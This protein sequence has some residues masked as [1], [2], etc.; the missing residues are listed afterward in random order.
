[1]EIWKQ[2]PIYQNYVGSNLG[3]VKSLNYKHT[4]KDKMLKKLK[5]IKHNKNRN[6]IIQRIGLC[7][8]NK[9]KHYLVHR[10]IYECFYGTIPEGFQIDHID[11]NPQNNRLDN[12]QLLTKS[13]NINKKF[14]DNPNLAKQMGKKIICLNNGVVY[15]SQQEAGRKL[16]LSAGNINSVLKGIYQNTKGYIF[17]YIDDSSIYEKINQLQLF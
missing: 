10:F 1:M 12:L 16:N 3:N 7:K 2:H 13:E 4:G 11:N 17:R 9:C 5:N 15:D 6:Y 8:N 14:I